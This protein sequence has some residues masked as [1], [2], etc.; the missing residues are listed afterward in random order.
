VEKVNKVPKLT[1]QGTIR[2]SAMF[3]STIDSINRVRDAGIVSK[4]RKIREEGDEKTQFQSALNNRP[5]VLATGYTRVVYGD[6]GPYVEFEEHHLDMSEWPKVKEKSRNAF[7]DER[8]TKDG[9]IMLYV[10]KKSVKNVPNPPRKGY[11]SSFNNRAEGYADYKPGKFYVSALDLQ[12][13]VKPAEDPEK[14][15]VDQTAATATSAR[16]KKSQRKDMKQI[17]NRAIGTSNWQPG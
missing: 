2:Q 9:K 12:I 11:F 8:F 7:Y 13:K 4:Y 17:S 15:N 10:Q 5:S 14:Q 3:T 6:H 1:D 16:V